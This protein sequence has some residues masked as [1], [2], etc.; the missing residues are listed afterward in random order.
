MQ[1]IP[2]VKPGPVSPEP[3]ARRRRAAPPPPRPRQHEDSQGRDPCALA[4]PYPS[5]EA[6]ERGAW[7]TG[8]ATSRRGA[9]L[10]PPRSQPL[11]APSPPPPRVRASSPALGSWRARGAGPPGSAGAGT[12]AQAHRGWPSIVLL[13]AGRDWLLRLS[14]PQPA[15]SS[16]PPPADA[17]GGCGASGRA[18]QW[19]QG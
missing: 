18:R 14:S 7:R 2:E 1:P 15:W 19:A 17:E 8:P 6:R 10:L 13:P 4:A 12:A 9:E 16:R 3:P 11:P 5:P